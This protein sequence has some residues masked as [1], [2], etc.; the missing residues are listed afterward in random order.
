MNYEKNIQIKLGQLFRFFV[1]NKEETLLDDNF[2]LNAKDFF[3]W[4]DSGIKKRKCNAWKVYQEWLGQFNGYGKIVNSLDEV[5]F[6]DYSVISSEGDS[7]FKIRLYYFMCEIICP[8]HYLNS[9]QGLC[10]RFDIWCDYDAC[11]SVEGIFECA[12]P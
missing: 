8:Q 12:F 9:L 1:S 4:N 7:F 2:V 10:E 5:S 3:V 6:K 11:M